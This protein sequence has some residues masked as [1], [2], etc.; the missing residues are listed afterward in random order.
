MSTTPVS[1][2]VPLSQPIERAGGA[3]AELTL[4]K[5]ATGELRGLKLMDVL[6][7]DVNALGLLLPRIAAPTITKADVDAMA[8]A[9]LMEL[10][11]AVVGFFEAT[12][13]AQS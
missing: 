4:R 5:P 11:V 2:V 3:V 6:Q 9:D 1:V 7:M 12:K 13:P 10:G 8:L